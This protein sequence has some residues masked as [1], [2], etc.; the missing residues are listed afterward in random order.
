MSAS[1][2]ATTIIWYDGGSKPASHSTAILICT[3][4]TNKI[5]IM[6]ENKN[7]MK[8]NNTTYH[9]TRITSTRSHSSSHS[10]ATVTISGMEKIVKITIKIIV[11]NNII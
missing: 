5:Y 6:E 11:H 1:R 9:K 10:I 3:L 8:K 7:K 2:A 4:A